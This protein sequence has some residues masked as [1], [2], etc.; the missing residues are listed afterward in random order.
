MKLKI[1]RR[2]DAVSEVLGTILIL[3][4]SVMI[5]SVVYISFFSVDVSPSRPNVYIAGSIKGNNLILEHSGGESLPLETKVSVSL[6]D[7]TYNVCEVKDKDSVKLTEKEKVEDEKEAKKETSKKKKGE[8][9]PSKTKEPTKETDKEVTEDVPEEAAEEEKKQEKPDTSQKVLC[10]L[11]KSVFVQ[12]TLFKTSECNGTEV[13][14][15][16]LFALKGQHIIAQG[17][18]LG[19]G[20]R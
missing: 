11:S 1:L 13:F 5:F 14:N 12:D 15:N 16:V 7:G 8:I 19:T 3:V 18:A 6:A 10:F 17:N 20:L 9:T 2:Y 4:I